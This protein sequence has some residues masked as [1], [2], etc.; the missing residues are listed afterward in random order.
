MLPVSVHGTQWGFRKHRRTKEIER[1]ALQRL[2]AQR[3]ME[4]S[5]GLKSVA[6]LNRGSDACLRGV[7]YSTTP[8]PLSLTSSPSRGEKSPW[9][10]SVP[11]GE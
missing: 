2:K 9:C 3:K 1:E 11:I 7:C 6:G 4:A 5:K 10:Q 8:S